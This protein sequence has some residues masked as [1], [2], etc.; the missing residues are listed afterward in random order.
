MLR[1]VYAKKESFNFPVK[2]FFPEITHSK[3]NINKQLI[4]IM[5]L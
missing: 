4:K 3:I 5:A 2:F 1:L